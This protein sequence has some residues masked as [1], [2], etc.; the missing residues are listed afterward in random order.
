F[1]QNAKNAAGDFA[2][3]FMD[4]IKF[5]FSL[6][7]NLMDKK[8]LSEAYESL[9]AVDKSDK[10]VR[11]AIN[12]PSFPNIKHSLSNSFNTDL[13]NFVTDGSLPSIDKGL[14]YRELIS[15]W[16]L[17]IFNNKDAIECK[18]FDFSS[19]GLSAG[20]QTLNLGSGV[21]K[22]IRFR[23]PVGNPDPI[24]KRANDLLSQTGLV[25]SSTIKAANK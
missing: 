16:G 4:A 19:R 18:S 6:Y 13:V 2:G 7:G 24:L 1:N 22:T 15:T 14:Q 17:V 20:E 23:V 5:G 10:L 12:A 11:M 25:S 21:T 9:V 8:A 3:A